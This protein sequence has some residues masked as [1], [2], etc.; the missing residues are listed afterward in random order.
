ML[1]SP[2]Q[3]SYPDSSSLSPRAYGSFRLDYSLAP[4]SHQTIIIALFCQTDPVSLS[5]LYQLYHHFASYS[6]WSKTS[7]DIILFFLHHI[8]YPSPPFP[9]YSSGFLTTCPDCSNFPL[10]CPVTFLPLFLLSYLD[11]FHHVTSLERH[12]QEICVYQLLHYF[13]SKLI[14]CLRPSANISNVISHSSST[15]IT[16][17]FWWS[18][19]LAASPTS[20]AWCYFHFV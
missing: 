16:W 1:V 11:T 18:G 12:I 14:W 3:F 6:D 8:S 4:Q 20:H 15:H 19:S 10:C 5:S 17:F 7:C 9:H 2:S 13:M